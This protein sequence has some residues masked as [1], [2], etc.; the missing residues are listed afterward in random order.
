VK[1]SVVIPLFN[2]ESVFPE[3]LD[4]LLKV[5]NDLPAETE[6]IFVNDGSSDQTT[7]LIEEAVA[8]QD[9]CVGVHLSRNFGHQA[10]ISAGLKV[11]RGEAVALIDGDLQD[12]P[13]L[14]PQLYA[15]VAESYDVVY[16]VRRNRKEGWI[17]RACYF[18]Y[19]R[20][21]NK[22]TLIDLPLDAGDYCVMSRRVVTHIN[23]MPERNRYIRGLRSFVGFKQT[24]IPYDRGM[25]VGGTSKYTLN[26]LFRLATDGI[27]TFSEFPLRIASVV[28]WAIAM[29][30]MI[31]ALALIYWRIFSDADVPG[32]ATLAVAIA[33]LGG[34]QLICVGILGEYIARIHNEVKGRPAYIIEKVSGSEFPDNGNPQTTA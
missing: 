12:P 1:L 19:Y 13:E 28:G 14:I 27:F 11:S 16:A 30:C 25:R 32:F 29:V 31:Y 33:F 34:V 9:H 26:K 10:A 6:I 7:V 3:L 8:T 18:T 23:Q 24:G 4:R 15:K 22:I 17:K 20:M 21:L 2:E 5:R